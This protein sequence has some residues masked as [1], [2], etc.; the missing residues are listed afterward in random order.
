MAL[1]GV[2]RMTFSFWQCDLYMSMSR[3][4]VTVLL[5]FSLHLVNRLGG[6]SYSWGVFHVPDWLCN[7]LA[8][9]CNVI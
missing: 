9:D 1:L 2:L 5:T 3:E 6:S 8:E 7:F 4:R